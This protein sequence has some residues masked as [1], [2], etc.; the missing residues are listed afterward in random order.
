[1]SSTLCLLAGY[2]SPYCARLLPDFGLLSTSGCDRSG[3]FLGLCEHVLS[4]SSVRCSSDSFLGY[5]SLLVGSLP[6]FGAIYHTDS[7]VHSLVYGL[8]AAHSK[9][10]RS[11]SSPE[12]NKKYRR[13][14]STTCRQLTSPRSWGTFTGYSSV[15]MVSCQCLGLMDFECKFGLLDQEKFDLHELPCNHHQICH[16]TPHAQLGYP[17]ALAVLSRQI[18]HTRFIRLAEHVLCKHD[19]VSATP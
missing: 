8:F 9:F 11:S 16:I 3:R 10:P 2:S 5:D 19:G 17:T 6:T 12:R 14:P 15:Q 13:K 1:M 4:F 18:G 7:L